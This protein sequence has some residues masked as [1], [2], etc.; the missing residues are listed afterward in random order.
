MFKAH[1]IQFIHVIVNILLIFVDDLDV[2]KYLKINM[3]FN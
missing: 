1:N 3:V 2:Y